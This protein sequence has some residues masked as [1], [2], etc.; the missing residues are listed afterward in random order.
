MTKTD[1]GA[2]EW[3]IEDD[4]IRLRAWGTE[5]SYPLPAPPVDG[6][7]IGTHD[8]CGLRLVDSSGHTSRKHARCE[9]RKHG[10]VVVDLDSKNGI[11]LDGARRPE[12][13]LEP[14]VELGVG[15]LTLIAESRRLIEL[16]AFI[17]RLLGWAADKADLVDH[18]LRAIRMAA[19]RRM[20]LVLCGDGELA[21]IAQ[22]LHRHALGLERPFVVSDPRRREVNANVRSAENTETGMEAVRRARGG[23][24]CVWAKRL[25]RDFDAVSAALRDP[26]TKVQLV[27]CVDSP[28]QSRPYNVEPVVIP[29][30]KSRSREVG[31]VIFEY[32]E[33][34]AAEL[35]APPLSVADREWL[36]KH[37]SSSVSEIE[38]GTRRLVAIRQHGN[39]LSAA[40]K[41]LGMAPISLSRWIGRR[42][43]PG[44]DPR[45][46]R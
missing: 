15:G 43:L 21:L 18:A 29:P 25:P 20:P 1:L 4:V 8:S 19:T 2:T 22:A 40:A 17:S 13:R 9:R 11:R 38:K 33:E 42:A 41:V 32:S 12:V 30:L 10:W 28:R 39:N 24:L 6:L 3:R 45:K 37:S 14:G 7:M 35:T 26:A 31:R 27:V 46:P 23:T 34:A 5:T 16:R 44:T 36:Q